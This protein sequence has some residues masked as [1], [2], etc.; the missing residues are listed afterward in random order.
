[1]SNSQGWEPVLLPY[2]FERQIAFCV[3]SS[4]RVVSM[5]YEGLHDIDLGNAAA[6]TTDPAHA[7]DYDL[8]DGDALTMLVDGVRWPALGLH[9]GCP[10]PS[11]ADGLRLFVDTAAFAVEVRDE[12]GNVMIRSDHSDYP[13][14]WLVATFSQDG[15]LFVVGT[16]DDLWCWRRLSSW[17]A[18]CRTE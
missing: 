2:I 7:E 1:M 12:A 9:G 17:G 18:A 4:D 14:G 3:P 10:F 8:Y 15:K 11:T 5:S 16:P 13:P 6:C